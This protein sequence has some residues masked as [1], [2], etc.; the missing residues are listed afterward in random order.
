MHARKFPARSIAARRMIAPNA[1]TSA[2]LR[3]W[4]DADVGLT[5]VSG[6]ASA[7]TD[8]GPN[9]DNF[10]QNQAGDRPTIVSNWR[11]NHA[12]WYS[13]DGSEGLFSFGVDAQAQPLT[14]YFVAEWPDPPT[15]AG[16]TR[17]LL[18]SNSNTL[19]IFQAATPSNGG[20]G[21]NIYTHMPSMY[22]GAQLN[23]AEHG[24]TPGTPCIIRAVFNG[25]SS[26]LQVIPHG[27]R[28]MS[29]T[30]NVGAGTW[31][32]VTYFSGNGDTQCW[33]GKIASGILYAGTPNAT[34]DAQLKV[35]LGDRYNIQ[36][37]PRRTPVV[38][39]VGNSLMRG[40]MGPASPPGQMQRLL[41][42]AARCDNWG[43]SAYTTPM[44][45]ALLATEGTTGN[46]D[47]LLLLEVGNHL[48]QGVTEAV[49]YAAVETFIDT[50]RGLGCNVPIIVSAVSPRT[51]VEGLYPGRIAAANALMAAGLPLKTNVYYEPG[52]STDSVM[53]PAAQADGIHWGHVQNLTA[54]THW[55][56]KVTSV[57]GL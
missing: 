25:A 19:Q 8:S 43:H 1:V 24:P 11:N 39:C 47:A 35:W 12:A 13:L 9:A 36:L 30:G 32:A 57:L 29:V 10:L 28:L 5:N 51:D 27:G 37:A 54:G 46:P 45:T 26:S 16:Q 48:L 15:V 40:D 21:A 52:I 33:G 2:T 17:R 20:A 53:S 4:Y 42:N 18:L 22:G 31:G 7:W 44:L 41:G 6:K 3:S 38:S 49:A 14:L 50:A 55:A 34:E 23:L 56:N